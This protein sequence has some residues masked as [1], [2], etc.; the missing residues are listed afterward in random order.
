MMETY[1]IHWSSLK[2]LNEAIDKI[3]ESRHSERP[4]D[5]SI[6]LDDVKVE[7]DV[8]HCHDTDFILMDSAKRSLNDMLRI[9]M[10]LYEQ[11]SP[12]VIAAIYNDLL[13]KKPKMA[14]L[15]IR[16]VKDEKNT[17]YVRVILQ[18]KHG[19][20]D[21]A[22]LFPFLLRKIP[23]RS[24]LVVRHAW[25]ARTYSAVRCVFGNVLPTSSA[26]AG[27]DVR[28]G[29]DVVNSEVIPNLT[30]VKGVIEL[31][32]GTGT[33][34]HLIIP[35]ILPSWNSSDKSDI[36]EGMKK[37]FD[38]NPD[39]VD[40]MTCASLGAGMMEKTSRAKLLRN[41][42]DAKHLIRRDVQEIYRH[43]DGEL[44]DDQVDDLLRNDK[45]Q[46]HPLGL[47]FEIGTFATNM[48]SYLKRSQLEFIP[49]IWFAKARN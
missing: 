17:Q 4:F 44:K 46:T 37:F 18:S 20:V 43:I 48:D 26:K 15:T 33:T 1:N 39:G 5:L 27:C 40:A 41:L 13:R 21:D 38:Y 19:I 6:S 35:K 7:G 14:R 10:T 30:W 28:F 23:A 12:D 32:D 11:L 42:Y 3:L 31:T 16:C 47:A 22:I 36:A 45:T 9:P 34:C 2:N 8:F 25:S 49:N 29:F 24:D